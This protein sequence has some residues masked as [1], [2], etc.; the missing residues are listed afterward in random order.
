MMRSE[1][2]V[3]AAAP[4]FIPTRE[5]G[6]ARLEAF[7]P[8]AGRD[9]KERRNF[10]LG[11]D[12]RDN[13]S[14][15][16]PWIR[17]R[18]VREDEVLARVLGRHRMATAA[19]F[20]Q[21]V[22]WRTYWKGWLE[23]RPAVWRRYRRAVAAAVRELD[24]DAGLRGRYERA[25]C[26]RTGIACFDAWTRELLAHGYLHNHARMWFAS[27]WIFT[28]GLPWVLGADLF[29]RHLLDGD[30][31]SNTLSWRWVAGL[32]TPGKTYLARS[33]N[34]IRYTS[35]RFPSELRLADQA[36]IIR[37]PEPLPLPRDLPPAA[38]AVRP[39][40][41]GVLIT[42]D[43]CDPLSLGLGHA[44]VR[45]A[46]AI[47]F[48]SRRSPLPAGP[49]ARDFSRGACA[50]A[51]ARL[52]TATGCSTAMLDE[53]ATA[54]VLLDWSRSNGLGTVVTAYAPAGPAAEWLEDVEPALAASGVT[55]TRIRRG[56]DDALWPYARKGYFSFKESV[57]QALLRLGI[58]PNGAQAGR[59]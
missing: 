2:P 18:L 28:L 54:D 42:E 19:S 5:A 56:W 41:I 50:D 1:G 32:Q 4:D 6:L 16:S 58:G 37:E 26:G 13:V 38:G 47:A 29:F 15:L 7:L 17:H 35:G 25:T 34:I 10:D 23:M 21:E 12:R 31:A 48:T 45:A 24:G 49:A 14:M 59:R 22:V 8:R 43:D 55:L 52:T 39:G 9:Y 46:A 30:P 33:D 20:V 53:D 11:P 3:L 36:L 27:I 57:P 44:T 51:L 40:P